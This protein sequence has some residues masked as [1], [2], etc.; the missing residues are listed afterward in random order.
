MSIELGFAP[1]E[2]HK[3]LL[4]I[5]F[6]AAELSRAGAA[7]IC[8][9]IA[10]Y[11]ASRNKAKAYIVQNGGAGGGTCFLVHVATPFEYCEK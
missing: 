7:V 9:P 8:S 10:P 1:E 4:R 2:R 5:A 6:V 3:N 11:E